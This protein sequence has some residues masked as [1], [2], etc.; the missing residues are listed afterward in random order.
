VPFAEQVEA[1]QE[2]VKTGKVRYIGLSNET[3]YG[4]VKFLGAVSGLPLVVSI[5]NAYNLIERNLVETGLVEACH[6]E[7]TALLAHSPLAGGALTGKYIKGLA[8]KESRLLK[9]PGYTA[10]Y[11]S[12]SAENAIQDYSS[13]ADKYGLTP[14]QLALSWCYSRSF[15][16]ST[17]IGATSVDHL[18]DNIMA[19]NCPMTPEMEEKINELYS[20]KHTDPTKSFISM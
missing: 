17:I 13:L 18:R 3:P 14:T 20:S 5:Q 7:R 9:Y 11:L 8:T 12:A 1:M 4:L 6:Y 10:Q 2:L 19:L 16:T 15:I